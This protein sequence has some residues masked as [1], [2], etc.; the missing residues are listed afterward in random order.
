MNTILFTAPLF[1]SAVR[2]ALKETYG[3]C[4]TVRADRSLPATPGS[5]YSFR[6][7]PTRGQSVAT[8]MRIL[9]AA[10][11]ATAA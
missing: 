7:G 1:A 6:F 9:D 10:K 2:A 3:D 11:A 4:I 8:G 5:A